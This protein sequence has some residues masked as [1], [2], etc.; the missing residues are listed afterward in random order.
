MSASNSSLCPFANYM[1]GGKRYRES[2]G[3]Q[4]DLSSASVKH[5]FRFKKTPSSFDKNLIMHACI[6]RSRRR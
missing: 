5:H 2:C 4:I 6:S 3:V 1:K